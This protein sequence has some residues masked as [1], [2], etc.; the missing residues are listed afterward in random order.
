M[1]I[2]ISAQG[3]TLN[4]M[5]DP[6]FGRASYF[7]FIDPE[8]QEMDTAENRQNLQ[9]PQG[10]GIQ[11]AQTVV[12]HKAQVLL[13]GNCGPKAFQVLRAAKIRVA[14]GVSG[15]VREVLDRYRR[16]ELSLAEGP[17]VE[18]HWGGS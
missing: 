14:T 5:V 3:N 17:N 9:L 13:T 2:A 8:T 15:T 18:G 10:A 4:S 6:R 1:K 12:D 7:I 11:A 16:G